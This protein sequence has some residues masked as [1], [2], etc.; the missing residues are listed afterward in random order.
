MQTLFHNYERN[1]SEDKTFAISRMKNEQNKLNFEGKK[2][3]VEP[4]TRGI[5]PEAIYSIYHTTMNI[6]EN[7][8][9]KLHF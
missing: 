1:Y 3:N 5:Q 8:T 2:K 4:N 6:L 9:D 7:E